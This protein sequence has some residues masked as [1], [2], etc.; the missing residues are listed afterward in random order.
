MPRKSTLAIS[1]ALTLLAGAATAQTPPAWSVDDRN[2][3]EMGS[4]AA[5]LLTPAKRAEYGSAMLAQLRY[6]NLVL[7]DPLLERWLNNA[8]A[9]LGK[10]S[11]RP[12]ERFTLFLIRDRQINA[13][14]TLGGY[15]G[16][17]AGLVLAADRE[18]EVAS[19][20]SHEIAHVTQD[21]VLRSVE[22]AQR[23]Q[24]PMLLAML[25]AIAAAQAG[26]NS[27]GNAAMAIMT[28]AMGLSAQR[29]INYTRSGEQEADR[30][31]MQTLIRSG[32]D[33]NAMAEFF[34]IL[35]TRM[36]ANAANYYGEDPPEYL[37]THPVTTNRMSEARALAEQYSKD[38]GKV[39][40]V[41]SVPSIGNANSLLPKSLQIGA[42]TPV[43]DNANAVRTGPTSFK[44]TVKDSAQFGYARERMRVLSEDSPGATLREYQSIE[45]NAK[46]SDAQQYGKA[47]A[48]IKA[49][50][51]HVREALSIL[52]SLQ[53]RVKDNIWIDV[54]TADALF[55]TGQTAAADRAF[56][57]LLVRY[58][59]DRAVILTY[60]ESLTNRND[61]KA[62][63]HA[64][65]VL[66]PLE[67][68]V[69]D[70]PAYW[71]SVG[72]AA[73]ESGDEVRAGVAFAENAYTRGLPEQALVQLETIKR[74]TDLDYYNR[75]RVEA[76]IAEIKPIV[77]ELR[78]Q[79]IEDP[80]LNGR[81]N[82]DGSI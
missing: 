50:G 19:V 42:G 7:E 31:G 76:R 34:G 60:A 43:G 37:M 29:Q 68:K 6:Y 49:Q 64:L 73:K 2:L 63:K 55:R 56:E 32:Y 57:T 14:A 22:R 81:R 78:R 18:D 74:R 8:G 46:L 27:S 3:P 4:S 40:D 62:A 1:L 61:A 30:I 36:R 9:T 51:G 38:P 69:N 15:I 48:L 28:G 66:R 65:N 45:R 24:L 70:D 72:R 25:G 20:L 26:G 12:S 39:Q 44:V 16:V 82:R 52:Q 10:N 13:F 75:A 59:A 67:D 33:A 54:T 47:V 41:T 35:Q 79:G 11:A 5:R 80:D 58:P 71:L 23:D 17:N 53:S 21:H 77:L